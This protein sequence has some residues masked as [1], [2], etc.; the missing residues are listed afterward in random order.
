[1]LGYNI[2]E[3]STKTQDLIR[4][5]NLDAN[6]DGRVNEENGELAELL[7]KT[8]KKD[9]NQLVYDNWW[10]AKKNDVLWGTALGTVVAG[11]GVTMCMEASTDKSFSGLRKRALK[12]FANGNQD[13]PFP[14]S[15]DVPRQIAELEADA[16]EQL[17][18]LDKAISGDTY[19]YALKSRE[20]LQASLDEERLAEISRRQAHNRECLNWKPKYTMEQVFKDIRKSFIKSNIYKGLGAGVVLAGV[21]L[22][23]YFIAKK[24]DKTVE[25]KHD[26]V[27]TDTS[28]KQYNNEWE[29][30]YSEAFGSEAD[31]IEYTPQKGEYWI[32]ILQAKYSTDYETAKKMA[33]KIKEMIYGDANAA[34][35]TPI[36]YLPETWNF[37]G[38]TY[39][40]NV[41]AIPEKTTEY[42]DDIVTEQGKMSKDLE[43]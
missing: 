19:E 12:M 37:E 28:S 39:N 34:K 23:S 35:Q 41:D 3:L 43:Y 36:M 26:T 5:N 1:M 30:K 9:I 2:T 7:A 24:P 20:L 17:K 33:N 21:A 22:A 40:Y 25:M 31:L 15:E 18:K 27:S 42:S 13:R 14:V 10:Q 16:M 6:Q 4:Q 32:S 38:K 8:G 29:E 11:K